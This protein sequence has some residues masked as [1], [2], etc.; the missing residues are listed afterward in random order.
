MIDLLGKRSLKG[1]LT[2]SYNREKKGKVP[3]KIYM[4]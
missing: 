4:D 2:Q 1:N 3:P